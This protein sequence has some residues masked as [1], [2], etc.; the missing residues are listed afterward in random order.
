MIEKDENMNLLD[1]QGLS[2]ATAGD[3]VTGTPY[4]IID[5]SAAN[6]AFKPDALPT[7]YGIYPNGLLFNIGRLNSDELFDFLAVYTGPT[8]I[9]DT[10]IKVT[11]DQ[12]RSPSCSDFGDGAISLS[13]TGPATTYS[14]AWNNSDTTQDINGLLEGIYRCTITDNLGNLHIIDPI[15]LV[16]PDTISISFLKN[17]PTSTTSN[18]G[19]IIANV[20][21]GTP[22]YQFIWSNG[23]TNDRIANL[24]QGNYSLSVVD[25]K[26]CQTS[27]S[28]DLIVPSCSFLVLYNVKP[29]S[30]DQNPDGAITVEIAGATPPVT[31]AWSNGA[32]TQSLVNVPSGGYELTVTDNL[33]CTRIIGAMVEIEDNI[34]PAARTRQGPIRLYL[35]ENGV[36]EIFAE[37]VDSGSFDNC[38]ILDMQLAQEFFDCQDVGRNFV[39]FT[40][41]DFNLN[42]SSRDVE[43]LV[44]DTIPPSYLCTDDVMITACEGIVSYTIPQVI[45]NC[46][47]G[48]VTIFDGIGP[49]KNFPL[50]TSLESYTYV[51]SNGTRLEC[52]INVTVEKRVTVDI[53]SKDA[54]CP[55][56]ADGSATAVVESDLQYTFR[57][58]NGETTPSATNLLPG[59]DTV[60]ISEPSECAFIKNF[61]VGEPTNLFIRLDSI[62]APDEESDIYITVSG[63]TPP[64]RYQWKNDQNAVVSTVQDPKNL[65]YG[66]YQI[67]VTDANGCVTSNSIKADEATPTEEYIYLEGLEIRPNPTKGSFYL[68]F[69]HGLGRQALV[70][71]IS[72]TGQ[73]FYHHKHQASASV[74]IEAGELLPGIYLVKVIIEGE[75]LTKKLVIG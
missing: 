28:T 72:L 60:K 19:S 70:E 2:S 4:P 8:S 66:T 64:Y 58:S 55:G 20:S 51:A 3:W 69:R 71:I 56:R 36:A 54:T 5:T 63:G 40:V 52:D 47:N 37:Q 7:I 75:V 24:G 41:I 14:Y 35:N 53:Q 23:G 49:G 73:L 68:N 10:M 12:A 33:K 22:L 6:V 67:L 48:S 30:C 42:L 15:E 59:N 21:G 62:K 46:P 25:S 11:I 38:G 16:D 74:P 65:T 57:W 1:L 18:D 34:R 26:G 43:I 13:V 27:Q 17:T 31:F 44:L 61:S 50:G 9:P 45:D 39:E 29:T 32:T